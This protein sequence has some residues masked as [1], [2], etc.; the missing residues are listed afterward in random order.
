M[1]FYQSKILPGT[2]NENMNKMNIGMANKMSINPNLQKKP[3]SLNNNKIN[4]EQIPLNYRFPVKSKNIKL[5]H[6]K[7]LFRSHALLDENE[8]YYITYDRFNMIISDLFKFEIPILTHTYLSYRIFELLSRR[9]AY[10]VYEVEFVEGIK[11]LFSSDEMKSRAAFEVMKYPVAMTSLN[12]NPKDIVTLNEILHFF[13]ISWKHGFHI[14]YN[15]LRQY[16]EELARKYFFQAEHHQLDYL[17]KKYENNVKTCLIESF[18]EYSAGQNN[19]F[20]VYKGIP[21][22]I[23]RQW[24]TKD[25][26]LEIYY[27]NKK[28]RIAVTFRCLNDIGLVIQ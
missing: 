13:M 23:F 28:L 14:L 25:H 7:E 3:G 26:D 9:E 17:I 11:L 22:E 21:Y 19:K 18:K 10:R 24:V 4:I 16:K 5:S 1:G 6:A 8:D 12:S 15:L 27:Y 20:D 2:N